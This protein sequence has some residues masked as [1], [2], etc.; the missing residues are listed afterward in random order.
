M[1]KMMPRNKVAGG[2]SMGAPPRKQTANYQREQNH[3][4]GSDEAYTHVAPR[5]VHLR[6]GVGDTLS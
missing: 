6:R 4:R 2:P 5:A 3:H 1:E